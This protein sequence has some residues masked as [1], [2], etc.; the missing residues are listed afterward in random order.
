[1]TVYAV[2][3]ILTLLVV[4]FV[5]SRKKRVEPPTVL[6]LVTVPVVVEDPLPEPEVETRVVE[7]RELTPQVIASEPEPI[8][9]VE[10]DDPE[11]DALPEPEFFDEPVVEAIPEPEAE[12]VDL[13]RAIAAGAGNHQMLLLGVG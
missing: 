1:M 13:S 11:W 8:T 4:G 10:P 2:I 5:L 6:P 9:E 3:A 7:T 12:N